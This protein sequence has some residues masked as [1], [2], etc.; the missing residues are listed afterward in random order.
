MVSKVKLVIKKILSLKV[1]AVFMV[2]F[3]A[4]QIFMANAYAKEE[5]QSLLTVGIVVLLI[6]VVYTIIVIVCAWSNFVE[7][8]INDFKTDNRLFRGIFGVLAYFAVLIATLK[9]VG[10]YEFYDAWKENFDQLIYFLMEAIPALIGAMGVHYTIVVQNQNRQEDLR[11]GVK[12]FWDVKCCKPNVKTGEDNHLVRDVEI[13]IQLKNISNNIGIPTKVEVCEELADSVEL[14][15][16]PLEPQETSNI[17]TWLHYKEPVK[18]KVSINLYYKDVL[19][20]VYIM[21]IAFFLYPGF[22]L[23]ATEV[24]EDKL[25]SRK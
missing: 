13:G 16:K 25:F 9:W 5:S 4:L 22:E 11:L 2:G 19:G 14:R 24:I 15:Y 12:P 3:I 20:N 7:Q 10:S 8:S 6:L 17:T 18:D 1:Y 21:Q 23:A